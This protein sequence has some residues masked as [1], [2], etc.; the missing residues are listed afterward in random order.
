MRD[1]NQK[2]FE[3]INATDCGIKSNRLK[4]FTIAPGNL[5]YSTLKLTSNQFDL[6]G[7]IHG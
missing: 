7:K 1:E 2:L 5:L 4:I 3:Y 6:L